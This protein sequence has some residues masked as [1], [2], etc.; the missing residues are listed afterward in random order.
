M[1][2]NLGRSTDPLTHYGREIVLEERTSDPTST[3]EGD[4]WL[5]V[6]VAPETNQL[7]TLRFDHGA[8]TWDIPIFSTGTS[9]TDVEEVLRIPIGGTV[10]YL[11]VSE[12]GTFSELGF[13]HGGARHSLHN[14]F[15]ISIPDSAVHRWKYSE[16]SGST[17]ADSIGTSDGTVSGATWVSGTYQAGYALDGDGT[18]DVVVTDTLG[19]YGS[20]MSS[21]FAFAATAELDADGYLCG[22]GDD[23][24]LSELNVHTTDNQDPD[25]ASGEIKYTYYDGANIQTIRTDTS[26]NY[27]DGARRRYLVTSPD[28]TP[29]NARIYVD[30]TEVA[31]VVSRNDGSI[32]MVD[33]SANFVH[34][35]G[36]GV[37][38]NAVQDDIILYDS[39]LSGSEVQDDYNAQPWS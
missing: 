10:G 4:A 23:S 27:V 16:G 36:V 38:L 34:F 14:N 20:D 22:V 11:P 30:G 8:G 1:S 26:T 33:F 13:Q 18:D 9:G 31:T 39:E 15:E 5:R 19:T 7:G 6:D 17:V 28:G 21:G 2:G 37:Y 35:N 25:N 3:S 12:S 29:Q 32:S 24:N